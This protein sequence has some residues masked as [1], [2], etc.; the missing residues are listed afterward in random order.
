MTADHPDFYR[1]WDYDRPE[2][3]EQQFRSLLPAAE[4]TG[5][6]SYMAELLTQ[7]ARAQGLQRHFDAAHRTL[8]EAEA[9]LG[10]GAARPM[11]RYLL[12]RGRV[13]NSARQPGRARP[14]F[15]EAWQLATGHRLDF[16]AIDAAHMLAIIEPP[17]QHLHWNQLALDL[18][19][20]S[21]DPR[22]RNWRGSLHNNIG[23]SYHDRGQ[24]QEA[25]ESF[26]TALA[27]R[28]E[29]G[30]PADIPRCDLVHRP[31]APLVGAL[32]GSA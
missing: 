10:E 14:L 32:C 30:R 23:W 2:R 15:L 18:A 16:Y 22:A 7:I 19:E 9:L 25:L 8:D 11:V 13:F 3:S 26:R 21:A 31:H 24:Y 4:A 27:Y 20:G 12:E 6:P 28:R 17:D 5:E 1:L 29:Q